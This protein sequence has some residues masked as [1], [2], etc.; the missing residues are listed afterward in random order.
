MIDP[1]LAKAQALQRAG[2]AEDIANMA[3]FLASDEASWITGAAMVVDGGFTAGTP[4]SLVLEQSSR[5]PLAS[6]ALRFNDRLRA[7]DHS[8]RRAVGQATIFW[9][10]LYIGLRLAMVT[11][12]IISHNDDAA[13]RTIY[14]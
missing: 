11:H 10:S 4:F 12:D 2:E 7:A 3:L 8:N 14:F 6:P 1:L 5:R 13:G 9:R